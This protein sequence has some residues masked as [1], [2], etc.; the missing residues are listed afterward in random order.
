MN[1]N[2]AN[3]LAL[4]NYQT[5]TSEWVINLL[6]KGIIL[7]KNCIILEGFGN[8]GYEKSFENL[9]KKHYNQN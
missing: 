4:V 7:D 8:F 6:N 2:V 1:I 5:T 9:L 3:Q